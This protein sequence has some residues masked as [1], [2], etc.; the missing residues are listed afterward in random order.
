MNSFL[1]L[2]SIPA[3]A[4][5]PFVFISSTVKGLEEYR[6]QAQEGAQ[7]AGCYVHTMEYF[8]ASARGPSRDECL[9]EVDKAELMAVVRSA[10]HPKDILAEDGIGSP[11][12]PIRHGQHCMSDSGPT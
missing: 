6:R 11:S 2:Q 9:R 12:L 7:T 8:P 10:Q 5:A 1:T 4:E 3:V